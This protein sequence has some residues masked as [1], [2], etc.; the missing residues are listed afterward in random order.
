V[1][2][3]TASDSLGTLLQLIKKRRVHRLVVVE[4]E[5]RVHFHFVRFH[6]TDSVLNATQEEERQGGKKGRLL[7]IITLSDVLRYV[8]G[9][10]GI[11]E[12]VEPS[13]VPT[14]APTPAPVST[15]AR[16]EPEDAPPAHA[17][18]IEASS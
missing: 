13:Q 7:G 3:C 2:V 15:P 8:I 10:V 14:P 18:A 11:G 4:G 9:E 5:V 1:V 6:T 16:E 17:P 12:S